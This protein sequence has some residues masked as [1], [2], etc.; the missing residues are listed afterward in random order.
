[1]G[2]ERRAA[3]DI[4][5]VTAR[6]LVA[7]VVDGEIHELVRRSR[8]THLGEGWSS[9]AIL[10]AEGMARTADAV[11]GFA[12]EARGLGATRIVAVATSASRDASNS[13]EFLNRLEAVGSARGSSAG[14]ARATSR[15]WAPPMACAMSA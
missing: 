4:G 9:T 11:A 3:I 10:S 2:A 12:S 1:M 14:V 7:D 8:I 5:T 13:D 6:L 15:S